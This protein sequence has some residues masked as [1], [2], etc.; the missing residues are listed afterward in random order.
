MKKLTDVSETDLLAA[1][2]MLIFRFDSSSTL[3]MEAICSYE[4]PLIFVLQ[5]G[6]IC[7]KMEVFSFSL[8]DNFFDTN[9]TAYNTH[10]SGK[11][12]CVKLLCVVCIPLLL[13]LLFVLNIFM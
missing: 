7:W 4:I 8:S 10:C 6:V 2:F 13:L 3:K 5:H 12:R 11:C 9:E 1:C